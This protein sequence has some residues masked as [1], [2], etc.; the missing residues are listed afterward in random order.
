MRD[1]LELLSD[2]IGHR[3]AGAGLK[4][5]AAESCTGGWIAKCVT[6]V[7]GSS[8]WFDRGFVTYSNDAKS[9]ML[10]VAAETL[11]AYGAVSE[12]VVRE[13]ALG[14]LARSKAGVSIA[15]SGVAGPGGGSAEKPVGTVCF[16][17]VL[18]GRIATE[19]RRFDGA[20]DAVRRQSVVHAMRRLLALLSDGD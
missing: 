3:L 12:P 10:G 19:T 7:A 15:V 2:E 17:F 18:G 9:E 8:N 16:G 20:R 6:D 14:A 13:M 1:D 5:A 11:N 4:L